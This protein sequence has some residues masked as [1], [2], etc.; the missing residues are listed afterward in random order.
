[1]VPTMYTLF[2]RKAA[3]GANKTPVGEAPLTEH[4]LP[5]VAQPSA[6]GHEVV[7]K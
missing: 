1:V 2:A 3:P 4:D 6:Q 7:A 5:H